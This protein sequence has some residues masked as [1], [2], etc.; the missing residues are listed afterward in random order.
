[1]FNALRHF[2]ETDGPSFDADLTEAAC[3]M[4]VRACD[5]A[6]RLGLSLAGFD[7]FDDWFY[8]HFVG[9]GIPYSIE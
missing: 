2:N 9:V 6:R 1:M 4:L 5:N 8:T 3:W 7:T